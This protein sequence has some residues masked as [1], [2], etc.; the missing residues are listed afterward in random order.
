MTEPVALDGYGS[1]ATLAD[2]V[3]S[4]TATNAMSKGALGAASRTIALTD[5][6]AVEF[7]EATALRN[8][9][10]AVASLVGKTVV[11]FRR[12]QTDVARHLFTALEER[13]AAVPG[14]RVEGSFANEARDARAKDAEERL[15]QYDERLAQSRVLLEQRRAELDAERARLRDE[16]RANRAQ[17]AEA[18][19]TLWAE[20]KDIWTSPSADAAELAAFLDALEVPDPLDIG[21]EIAA[22]NDDALGDSDRA[23]TATGT[24]D[25]SLA[26]TI[27][28]ALT[29]AE[30][31]AAAG[32]ISQEERFIRLAR[33]MARTR[34]GRDVRRAVDDDIA[35]RTRHGTLRSGATH[36][37]TI[38]SESGLDRWARTGRVSVGSRG[39]RLIEVWTDRIITAS[40]AYPISART[41]AQVYLDGQVIVT[42]RP[43][44]TRMALFAPLPGSTLIPGLAFQK[45]ETADR[46]RAQV[47]IRDVNWALDAALDPD[48]LSTPRQ[49]AEQIN[50]LAAVL[51]SAP[52]TAAGT[53]LL[54]QLERL[55]F[56]IDKGV[57]SEAEAQAIKAALLR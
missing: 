15:A 14:A 32:D 45:K 10:I 11:Y 16:M 8:G 5:I 31:A 7:R 44:L 29:E 25:P 30:V 28:A 21:D 6:V 53:D 40:A 36:L 49:L 26:E 57:V 52:P 46:R 9:S 55:T 42:Q 23:T 22:G 4:V 41:G 18:T 13:S 43:T 51:A 48:V 33:T 38:T 56:L 39:E 19:R 50:A 34:G 1:I 37:G 24:A 3:L 54:A 27:D 20:L 17:M 47:Q 35:R 12:K 2:G